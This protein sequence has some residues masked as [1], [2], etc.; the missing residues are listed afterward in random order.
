[1]SITHAEL[2]EKLLK[3]LDQTRPTP[4]LDPSTSSSD[5]T[6]NTAESI[7]KT[8]ETILHTFDKV[9]GENASL[10]EEILHCYHQINVATETSAL[11]ARCDTVS[12]AIH[13]LMLEVGQAVNCSFSIFIKE[14]DFS[15][16][17]R[18]ALEQDSENIFLSG[19]DE[20]A[21]TAAKAYYKKNQEALS[22]LSA[23]D[24]DHQIAMI[25]YNPQL[26]P[27]YE[28]RGNVLGLSLKS[29]DATENF[30]TLIFV[31][32]H[33]QEPF[34]ASEVTLSQTLI[35]LGKVVLSNIVY[36][37]KIHQAYLQ[38]ITSL[39]RAMEEKDPYTSGHSNRVSDFACELGRRLGLPED[40]LEIL[41]WAGLLHDIGK[42][43]IRDDVLNK[44]GK[45]TDEE[46]EHIKTH[47]VKSFH[48]LEPI[49]ALQCILGAAR[50][51]HE[52]YDGKGY[53]DGLLGQDIPLHARIIQVADVWDAL[54]STRSYRN[55]MPHEKAQQIL[56]DEAG[57]TMDPH[58]V[59]LFLEILNEPQP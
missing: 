41:E 52:H 58:L 29:M 27:H 42:I 13:T 12:Q 47:P 15:F 43:G 37:Q 55:A 20:R 34:V 30:G 51:H 11:V 3:L 7:K 26:D 59:K 24:Q 40:E 14:M 25:D 18:G 36:A 48:V 50:H 56:R 54:T 35:K 32:D 53:P 9:Q 46:F 22:A 39:V 1:M 16:S 45:L 28:G 19:L 21:L 17:P 10:A 4:P 44:P 57:T 2:S 8:V 6:E 5:Q 23:K 31:R 38:T 33:D 49:D